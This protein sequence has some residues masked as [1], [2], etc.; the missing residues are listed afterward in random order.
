[1]ERW[2]LQ[3]S[4]IRSPMEDSPVSE[5]YSVWL[6]PNRGTDAYQQLDETI[7]KYAQLYEDAPRFDPHI[8]VVG[9]I[10]GNKSVLEENIRSLA[11]EQ[12]PFDAEFIKVQCSTTRHQCVF[13]LVE[14]SIELFSLHQEMS[15]SFNMSG[16]MYV[17]HL[18]L[19]YSDM[20]IEER[21]EM[22][23]S[24]ELSSLP[25]TAHI[26]AVAFIETT[27]DASDWEAVRIY[28]L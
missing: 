3:T 15:E 11:K 10:E 1:M 6:L 13:L 24:I 17:P 9:G 5:E 2:T 19:V 12:D 20:S 27:G 28:D 23:K 16:G 7:E 22:V 8:T 26:N 14:P 25:K 4:T 18:S 21:L